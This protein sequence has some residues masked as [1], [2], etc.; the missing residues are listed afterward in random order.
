MQ[1]TDKQFG[2]IEL[3]ENRDIKESKRMPQQL[4]FF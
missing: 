2:M 1:I 4:E 3:F